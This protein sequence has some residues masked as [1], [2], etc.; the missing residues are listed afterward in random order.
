MLLNYERYMNLSGNLT[1]LFEKSFGRALDEQIL[2]WRY[3]DNPMKDVLVAVQIED[4][5]LVAN[6]SASP[7][8][9]CI[10]GKVYKT[11]LSMTT[12]THPDYRGRGL[13]PQLANELYDHMNSRNYLM[14]WGFPNPNS[15]QTFNKYLGWKDIFSIPMM[16]LSLL[17]FKGDKCIPC[18]DN[19][20]DLN[21]PKYKNPQGL[22]CVQ[23]DKP[24]L[25]WRYRNNPGNVYQ[26]FIIRTTDKVSSF[27]VTKFYLDT[28]D[29]VDFQADNPDEGEYLLRQI[30]SLGINK[31]CK[32]I[33]CWAP[34]HHF[35]Y[36]LCKRIG[37]QVSLHKTNFGFKPFINT[38]PESTV[39]QY[40]N[41]FIQPGDSD[42]Y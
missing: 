27:C 28:L 20:F 24:Y 30:I 33:Y 10:D 11:G 15:H 29:L 5:R 42:V 23:K 22:I 2:R 38:E 12:M 25:R 7:C 35:M 13:F 18:C 34:P 1:E 6:Y 3:L 14:V 4:N 41:W 16:Q 39:G 32:Y 21:Y 26:N 19:D 8:L 37:F 36:S 31:G 40:V 17:E 9:V